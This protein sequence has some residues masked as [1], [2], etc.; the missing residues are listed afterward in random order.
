MVVIWLP[1]TVLIPAGERV[2]A[3]AMC[4]VCRPAAPAAASIVGVF[5]TVAVKLNVHDSPASSSVSPTGMKVT[6]PVAGSGAE[7]VYEDGQ[8]APG[9]PVTVNGPL[10]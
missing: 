7:T 8:T 1:A 2:W 10:S 9:D 5:R 4:A 6:A 3:V